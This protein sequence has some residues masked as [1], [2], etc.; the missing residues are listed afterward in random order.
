MSKKNQKEKQN[1]GQ[2]IGLKINEFG[3]IAL[4]FRGCITIEVDELN[5]AELH[6]PKKSAL[7]FM[8]KRQK[9]NRNSL[10][11]RLAEVRLT[12]HL[13]NSG[14]LEPKILKKL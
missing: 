3:S 2:K 12:Y 9:E 5:V 6:F 13:L 7:S 14:T 8:R 10:S 1:T 11:S 4:T